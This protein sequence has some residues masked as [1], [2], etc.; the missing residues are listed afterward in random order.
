MLWLPSHIDEAALVATL[1]EQGVFV[2]GLGEF[3]R[4][5]VV[6]PALVLGYAALDD[7][8]LPEIAMRIADAIA[9]AAD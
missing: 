5:Q 9:A 1:R 7:A 2:E 6:T 4:S 3:T 8:R